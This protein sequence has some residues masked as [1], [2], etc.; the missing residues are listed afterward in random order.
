MRVYKPA[1]GLKG[2]RAEIPVPLQGTPGDTAQV[3]APLCLLPT[4]LG[5]PKGHPK[6]GICESTA[7]LRQQ[8]AFLS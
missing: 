1:Q 6:L 5:V 7:P 4:W 3:R 2:V 8:Q